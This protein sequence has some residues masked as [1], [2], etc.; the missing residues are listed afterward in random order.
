M[1]KTRNNQKKMLE[2]IRNT[3]EKALPMVNK[4]LYNIGK[5]AKEIAEKSLPV[6]EEGASAVYGTISTGVDL[7]ISGAKTLAKGVRNISK[8]RR[9]KRKKHH[10]RNKSH[11]N[12]KRKH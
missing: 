1:K 9:H 3:T 4:G 10:S 5:T 8:K 6:V 11:R 12:K 2:S 7:G